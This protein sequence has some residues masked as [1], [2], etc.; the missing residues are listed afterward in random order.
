MD[1]RKL[2]ILRHLPLYSTDKMFTD[3]NGFVLRMPEKRG[4]KGFCEEHTI[5]FPVCSDS[6][7]GCCRLGRVEYITSDKK[8]AGL[9]GICHGRGLAHVNGERVKSMREKSTLDG[10]VSAVKRMSYSEI[11]RFENEADHVKDINSRL[12]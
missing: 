7:R 3:E 4:A 12:V 10:H 6:D 1:I 9:Y 8:S 11:A 2:P 5:P